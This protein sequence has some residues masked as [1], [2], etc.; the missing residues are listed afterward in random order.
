MFLIMNLFNDSYWVLQRIL[1]ETSLYCIKSLWRSINTPESTGYFQKLQVFDHQD[2]DVPGQLNGQLEKPNCL[3]WHFCF[4]QGIR[5][6][7]LTKYTQVFWESM[8]GSIDICLNCSNSE[9]LP[10]LKTGTTLAI[11]SQSFS[12]DKSNINLKGLY[13]LPKH[14]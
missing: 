5:K 14:F 6:I 4:L 1:K 7:D 13:H 12:N 9:R 8:G 11:L 3:V 2:K 10:P